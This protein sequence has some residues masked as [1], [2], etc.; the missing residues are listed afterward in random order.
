VV[1]A[2]AHQGNWEWMQL[3]CAA[4]LNIRIAT[5]YKPI[6]EDDLDSLL[7]TVRGRFGGTLIAASGSLTGLARFA[8]DGGVVAVL[9]DQGPRPDEEQYWSNFLGRETAFFPG[10]E[11]LTQ[12]LNAPLVFVHMRRTG[13]GHYRLSLE[14]LAEAPG[15]NMDHAIMERYIRCVEAQVRAAPEDWLWMYKRWKY[16]R[17]DI[18]QKTP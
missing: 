4:Q 15:N 17:A 16:R 13:K 8:R 14:Q 5:L 6:R 7:R 10:L 12:L 11:K 2:G 9:A 3:A 1:V 18:D